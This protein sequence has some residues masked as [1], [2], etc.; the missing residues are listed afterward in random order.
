[1]ENFAASEN[2]LAEP[3]WIPKCPNAL[4]C[5]SFA[6][7]DGP[8]PDPTEYMPDWPESERTHYQ[9]YET[10][11]E[12]SPISPVMESPEA[13]A[14]WLADNGASSFG[15]MTATYEQWLV[16]CRGNSAPSMVM[17]LSST[18]STMMSG[19]EAI[20]ELEKAKKES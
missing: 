9:M 17:A 8:E 15:S 3:K 2:C 19:V 16:V 7:W 14:R 10:C 1:M 6:D 11:S 20:A 13:L 12:G 18:G 5:R 4:K